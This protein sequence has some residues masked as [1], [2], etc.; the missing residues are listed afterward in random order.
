MRRGLL[1]SV[2]LAF[3]A[4]AWGGAHPASAAP[5]LRASCMEGNQVVYREDIPSDGPGERRAQIIARN[6]NAMC[7]FLELQDQERIGAPLPAAAQGAG[8]GRL[9]DALVSAAAGRSRLPDAELSAALSAI[10][11]TRNPLPPTQASPSP[12]STPRAKTSATE[13]PSGT[14]AL[15]IGIY[16]DMPVA[17]VMEHWR[18]LSSGTKVLSRMTPTITTAEDVTMLSVEGVTDGEAGPL[19]DEASE[20]GMGCLAAY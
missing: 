3:A 12:A 18:Q 4:A 17:E 11:G 19:C 7:V 6:P 15:T 5:M 16:R 14:V 13:V 20:R 10:T 8:G 9:P 1:A 2:G